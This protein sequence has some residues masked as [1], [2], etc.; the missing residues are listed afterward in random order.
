MKKIIAFGAAVS[1][2]AMTSIVAEA[3][4]SAKLSVECNESEIGEIKSGD[5]ITVTVTSENAGGTLAAFS[6]KMT[7]LELTK[8]TYRPG[9]KGEQANSDFSI[10]FEDNNKTFEENQELCVIEFKVTD[11][12]NMSVEIVPKN[13]SEKGTKSLWKAA[14]QSSQSSSSKSSASTNSSSVPESSSGSS[15]NVNSSKPSSSSDSNNS[16]GGNVDT[17]IGFAVIP[18]IVLAGASVVCMKKK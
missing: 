7:G 2:A 8:C 11:P 4:V 14:S 3:A 16:G 18:L 12:T 17:G 1:M 5:L 6:V 15:S 10:E 13:G 9:L